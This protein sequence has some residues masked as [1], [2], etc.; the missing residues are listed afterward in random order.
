MDCCGADHANARGGGAA[1]DA[2]VRSLRTADYYYDGGDASCAGVPAGH[3]ND[4]AFCALACVLRRQ[5]FGGAHF[6]PCCGEL[7]AGSRAGGANGE[8]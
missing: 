8:D 3:S 7:N 2:A 5:R 1:G 6:S 4:D